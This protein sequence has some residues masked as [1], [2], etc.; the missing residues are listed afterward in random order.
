MSRHSIPVLPSPFPDE[1]EA[2][3][4]PDAMGGFLDCECS[5]CREARLHDEDRISF[6]AM[7]LAEAY[8]AGW[9]DGIRALGWTIPFSDL[10]EAA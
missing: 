6:S 10:L 2:Y 5:Q 3:D 4:V 8:N 7:A 9:E 1:P